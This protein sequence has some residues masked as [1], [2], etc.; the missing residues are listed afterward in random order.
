MELVYSSVVVLVL[1]TLCYFVAAP[2]FLGGKEQILFQDTTVAITA[3]V[4]LAALIFSLALRIE[5]SDSLW[6]ISILAGVGIFNL[7]RFGSKLIPG[8]KRKYGGYWLLYWGSFVPFGGAILVAQLKMGLGDYP[9]VFFGLDTPLKL[10]DAFQ[11]SRSSSYPPSSLM[12]DGWAP[13]YHYGAQAVVGLISK[14]SR[15]DAHKVMFFVVAPLFLLA[16]H[17]LCFQIVIKKFGVSKLSV[18]GLLLFLP[19]FLLGPYL[20]SILVSASPVYEFL[21]LL[22]GSPVRTT[23]KSAAFGNGVWDVSVLS[24]M[25]LILLAAKIN[26]KGSEGR[27]WA[28]LFLIPPLAAF[29]KM[30]MVPA[31]YALLA[32]AVFANRATC[33]NIKVFIGVGIILAAGVLTLLLLGYFD[34][35]SHVGMIKIRSFAEI[36]SRFD[37]RWNGG[38]STLQQLYLILAMG[39]VG[40][41]NVLKIDSRDSKMGHVLS[42]LGKI[43]LG[44]SVGGAGFMLLSE[45]PTNGYGFA[46]FVG[47][48]LALAAAVQVVKFY[49]RAGWGSNDDAGRLIIAGLAVTA[50]CMSM[51]TFVDIAAVG[52]QFF[53]ATWVAIPLVGVGLLSQVGKGLGQKLFGSLFLVP[54][55]AVSTVAQWGKVEH[56]AVVMKFPENTEEY[57]K[58]DPL[59]AEALRHIPIENSLIVTNGFGF[60]G[61]SDTNRAIPALFGHQAYGVD[62]RH[63]PDLAGYNIEGGR[64]I[65]LQRSLFGNISSFSKEEHSR[66]TRALAEQMGWS[67]LLVKRELPAGNPAIN[68]KDL[69]FIKLFENDRYALYEFDIVGVEK[70][71]SVD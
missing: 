32:T 50:I 11:I 30:D 49:F 31:I 10:A 5:F 38:H 68:E 21:N 34:S 53:L 19:G 70:S 1:L 6:T 63:L 66:K 65:D 71:N 7:R 12:M 44:V 60:G 42:K 28:Y 33:S 56:L 3:G 26:L 67:H 46:L 55:I 36:H 20:W 62:L 15:L 41:F 57:A 39:V 18:V 22:F 23:Y 17:A 9:Q 16:T 43:M 29:A 54:I 69:P 47:V 8:R 27:I 25:V 64:R 37:W 59:L 2:L 13:A 40:L 52:G 35:A 48:P 61:W 58:V 51:I 14:V 4:L 45:D 24:G